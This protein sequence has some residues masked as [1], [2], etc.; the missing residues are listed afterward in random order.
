MCAERRS[1]VPTSPSDRPA[2][3][4]R[5]PWR[6]ARWIAVSAALLLPLLTVAPAHAADG[7]TVKRTEQIVAALKKD[8]VYV[9]P[10]YR[11]AVP[12]AR[13]E[14]LVAQIERTG[15]PL[16]VALVPLADGDAYA[17]DAGVLAELLHDRLGQRELIL[18]TT[19]DLS[20]WLRGYEWPSDQHQAEAAVNAVGHLP[21]MSEAGLATK[22]SKAIELVEGGRGEEVYR[23]ATADLASGGSPSR[24]LQADGDTDAEGFPWMPVGLGAGTAVAVG[25]GLV[26][27]QRRRAGGAGQPF[28]RPHAVIAAAREA[29][30]ARLR[31]RAEQEVLALGEA[32]RAV[33][34][35]PASATA[36]SGPDGG[37]DTPSGGGTEAARAALQ[38]ALDAYAAAGTVLDSAARRVDLAG[39]LALVAEGHD[40]LR[41][42]RHTA[43]PSPPPGRRGLARWASR[44][45]HPSRSAADATTPLPLCFFNPLHGR[46]A[47]R[48]AWR[49]LGTRHMLDVA[50]CS[51]CAR[52][53]AEHQAPE[54]LTDEW[55]GRAV[56]YFEVP[57]EHS[58]WAATGYGSL[59]D[60]GLAHRVNRGDHT[61]ATSGEH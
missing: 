16:K 52:A 34:L 47:R 57:A 51:E 59:V 25:A 49:P 60:D 56:P 38:Q 24:P 17:G 43:K 12:P 44:R 11:T 58:V 40:A 13:R 53:V 45:R 5:A 20:G 50:A 10:A 48:L 21:G 1:R 28:A 27:R 26:L 6:L 7:G 18:I 9:D 22:V 31:D 33:E 55:D 37:A 2:A 30:L 8:P 54:V 61:R 36:T 41:A 42:V 4:V 46:S 19:S 29:D 3:P 15:L 14:K 35:P 39:V 32:V 23:E